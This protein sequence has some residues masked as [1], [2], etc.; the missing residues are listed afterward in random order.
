[1]LVLDGDCHFHGCVLAGL[2]ASASV[3][4]AWVVGT[5][6]GGD[7]WILWRIVRWL[8]GV[9][10]KFGSLYLEDRSGWLGW[11]IDYRLRRRLRR[12]LRF[13]ASLD[14]I[15]LVHN[16]P[17]FP[18]NSIALARHSRSASRRCKQLVPKRPL[19]PV[20]RWQSVKSLQFRVLT[21][22]FCLENKT[23]VFDDFVI[24]LE[25]IENRVE[26]A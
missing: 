16:S 12:R 8:N 10:R 2:S 4:A 20:S 15:V 6:A 13:I 26:A 24:D 7:D 9:A 14:W 23:A 5:V 17:A 18:V 22:G 21:Y 11:L 19:L 1:M 25:S 3:R